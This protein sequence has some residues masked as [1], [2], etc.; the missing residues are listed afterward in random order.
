MLTP[1]PIKKSFDKPTKWNPRGSMLLLVP[2]I[3]PERSTGGIVIP[4]AVRR[5]A[6]SGF[7]A[8]RGADVP[9]DLQV[10]DEVFFEQ[11]QE[12]RIV[13]DD[14]E[15]EAILI[16]AYKVLLHLP[17]S[18]RHETSHS[19]GGPSGS[20][21]DDLRQLYGDYPPGRGK[22]DGPFPAEP[23]Q[24]VLAPIFIQQNPGILQ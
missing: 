21:G 3:E 22:T 6:T 9:P 7:I 1:T 12:Y 20:G 19:N 4:D 10:G 2:T 5:K 13:L 16:D 17:C 18:T 23:Q 14:N 15:E 24:H 8:N 11:H